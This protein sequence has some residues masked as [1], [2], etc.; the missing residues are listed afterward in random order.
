MAV[1]RRRVIKPPGVMDDHR[2]S[3]YGFSSITLFYIYFI[4]LFHR[5]TNLA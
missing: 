1:G 2:F 5:G 3:G 4:K